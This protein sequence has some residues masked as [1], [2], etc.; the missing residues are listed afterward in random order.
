MSRDSRRIIPI[1][2]TITALL[3]GVG[4]STLP[5]GPRPEMGSEPTSAGGAGTLAGRAR[6]ETSSVTT[7]KTIYGLV[8]GQ[9]SAGDF[10]VILP[11]LAISGTARVTVTQPDVTKPYVDLEISPASA[12]QFRLPVTL[13]A[14]AGLMDNALLR[15][16]YIG[17][18]NPST[19]K[20]ERVASST[21]S[22][23]DKTV[24][25]ELG[26]FSSYRVEA[27]SKAGW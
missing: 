23:A 9:V 20:W 18:Y 3:A 17:W 16:A 19:R 1:A 26:H 10:T 13:I 15:V 27:G 14:K 11:P 4:C 24:I 8:G 22:L 12:N 2:L 21:V 7:T 25:A 5:T 6:F